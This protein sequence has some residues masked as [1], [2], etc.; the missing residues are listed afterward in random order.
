MEPKKFTPPATTVVG[1]WIRVSTEDQV[2]GESPEH[3]E[4]RARAYAESKGWVVREVYRLEAVSGKSVRE[5]P[6]TQRMLADVK[7]G[8]VSALIFSKLA[9]LARNTRELLDFADYFRDHGADLV[10]LQESIDTTTPAGRLFYTMIAAMAQW[11]REEIADRVAA[12]VPIR[13]KMGKPLGGV[14]PFGY[15]W[16][17]KQLVVDETEAPVRRLLYE[18][19][20]EHRRKKA[21]ARILNDR[22]YRTRNGGRFT[23]TT[24]DRLLRDPTAKGLRRANYTTSRLGKRPTLKPESE[25][26]L[27]PAPAIVPEDLWA[28]CN[29]I[30][31]ERR[32]KL[33]PRPGRT[34]V[35][36][37]TGIVRC[38][39]G[40]KM[41]V[42]W[43]GTKYTCY[44]CRRKVAADAL[45]AIFR[46]QLKSFLLSPEDLAEALHQADDE[47]RSREERL[48]T[49]ETEVGK[50][51]AEMGRLY[52]LYASGNMAV[53]SYG[54]TAKP[55]EERQR[56][57]ED[58]IP[59]LRGEIDFLKIQNL[60]RDEVLSEAKDLATRWGGLNREEKRQI[61]ETVVQGITVG[62][63]EIEL[64]LAYFPTSPEI[65]IERQR[66][67]R[68]TVLRGG[69]RRY[70]GRSRRDDTGLVTIGRAKQMRRRER[71]VWLA[72]AGP[73]RGFLDGA[74]K[75][76]ILGQILACWRQCVKAKPKQRHS[77]MGSDHLLRDRRRWH[78]TCPLH[79]TRVTS[80]PPSACATR[81]DARR[82]CRSPRMAP[83]KWPPV[84]PNFNIKCFAEL[85][86]P[87]AQSTS[88]PDCS[89]RQEHPAR[90]RSRD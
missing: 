74:L 50:L 5:H 36:L 54:R 7:A 41:Y 25:W 88:I 89:Q 82:V 6:E 78:V 86:A 84:L 85:R 35:H 10:S 52:H 31:D 14:A 17:K 37:F 26:V 30:L 55:L 76:R 27:L 70:A 8:K 44:R 60:S 4:R 75:M 59:R 16:E 90:N 13:A 19:F 77:L 22:G 83:T 61:V 45:E 87:S 12:S 38:A 32:A 9:R 24:V 67:Q 21:V 20:L 79:R 64:D 68:D 53:E 39:C 18:L 1:V 51:Q 29:E 3:H 49:L 15:R 11:E 65:A 57:L 73:L 80:P 28:R 34:P 46:D 42:P 43:E 40:N 69:E 56:A 48:A 81:W 66:R 23:D 58:E 63:E 72:N 2:R 33:S 62:K 47:I 71:C